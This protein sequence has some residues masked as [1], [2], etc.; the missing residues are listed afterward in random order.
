MPHTETL[1]ERTESLILSFTQSVS[2]MNTIIILQATICLFVCKNPTEAVWKVY[3]EHIGPNEE[4]S[5]QPRV[6]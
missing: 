1:L 2:V 4:I 6:H 5:Q 3:R